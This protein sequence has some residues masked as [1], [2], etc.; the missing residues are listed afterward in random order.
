MTKS[1]IDTGQSGAGIG[2]LSSLDAAQ[3][4]AVAA[5]FSKMNS[6]LVL[7]GIA[8]ALVSERMEG[9]ASQ[10]LLALLA[11][12][13]CVVAVFLTHGIAGL[14]RHGQGGW[15]FAQ[16]FRGGRQFVLMQVAGWSAFGV[17]VL[18]QGLFI[19]SSIYLGT[20]V[21]PGTMYVGAL[22]ALLSQYVIVASLRAFQPAAAT[23]AAAAAPAKR[24]A[25]R[26]LPELGRLEHAALLASLALFCNLQYVSFGTYM[27]AFCLPYLVP[28]ALS[29]HV[30]A[31]SLGLVPELDGAKANFYH[32]FGVWFSLFSCIVAW[33][34]FASA[35]KTLGVRGWQESILLSTTAV[36]GFGA[37]LSYCAESPHHP[38][39][40]LLCSL[41][42]VYRSTT[43]TKRPESNA[44][45]EWQELRELPWIARIF[46]RFFGLQVLVS[47]RLARPAELGRADGE[48][49]RLRQVLLLFHPHS[50]FPLSHAGASLT[51]PWRAVFPH[52]K[53]NALTASIIHYVPVMRD[54]QQWFGA[55]D[56]SRSTVEA[57]IAMGRNVQIVCGGQTEMFESRS[58]DSEIRVVRARRLGIFRIAIRSGL[59]VVPVY[60][61]GETLTFDNV[62]LPRLQALLKG[63]LGF[64]FPFVMLGAWGLP[65][66]RRVPISI[67]VGA[68]VHPLQRCDD[69]TD[70][71]VAEMHAR[72]FAQ[73][74][75]LFD[76]FKEQCGHGDCTIKWLD[77]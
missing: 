9:V 17:A 4:A 59:P 73:L 30:A 65:L 20:Q 68:P 54:V 75:A 74:Q 63:W 64:P 43:F 12:V 40:V 32:T 22:A 2:L 66:P 53:V 7:I 61:F 31:L 34:V 25:Y 3:G 48:D 47:R 76:E 6:G 71:Q 72:Y 27:L 49:A 42:L 28:S 35:C 41:E 33:T 11:L 67:A 1:I 13:C 24:W 10:P 29:R 69:P 26:P 45:R 57:L 77:Q 38:M 58:W 50:I 19:V 56:V 23:A 16:A 36:L 39:L 60:S 14:L 18:A 52:L 62:Y 51:G 5:E 44:C 37:S 70:E 55:C 46:E 15:S 21:I 8:L